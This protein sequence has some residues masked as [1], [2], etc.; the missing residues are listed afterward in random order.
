MTPFAPYRMVDA[1]WRIE[2][3]KL[4]AV[5]T[6]FVRDIGLAEDLAQNVL[7]IALKKWPE[8]GVSDD[9]DA[10]LLTTAKRRAID[11]IR[12]N[13]LLDRKYEE[14]GRNLKGYHEVSSKEAILRKSMS[15]SAR[16][17]WSRQL[18]I[19]QTYNSG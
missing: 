5:L 6:R 16:F 15:F 1:V 9:P 10:W 17:G 13:Q 3:A 7:V 8:T 2:S 18:E 14:I 4:M 11:L 12:R 19:N